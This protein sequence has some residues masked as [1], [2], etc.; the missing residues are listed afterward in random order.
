[1]LYKYER[2]CKIACGGLRVLSSWH[3]AL[4]ALNSF[5]RERVTAEH[6]RAANSVAAYNGHTVT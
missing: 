4:T 6:A 1:M 3:H 2:S 5:S